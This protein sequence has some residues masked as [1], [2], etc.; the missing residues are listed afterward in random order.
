MLI[1][2]LIIRLLGPDQGYKGSGVCRAGYKLEAALEQF[3]CDV[4]GKVALDAGLSTG[5]FSDCLLQNGVKHIYGVDVGY[6]Q[7]AER[8]RTDPRVS[9]IER[10]NLRY[11]PCLPQLVDLVTLDLSFIS[12]LLVYWGHLSNF[13]C[14]FQHVHIAVS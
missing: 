7:V 5:G 1:S 6:G 12:I 10:T 2:F 9:V 11:L 13:G 8:I 4:E 3:A 14:I